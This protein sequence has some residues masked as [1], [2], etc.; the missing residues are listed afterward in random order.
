M[1]IDFNPF[2]KAYEEIVITV[3][4]AFS[5]V[6]K[7]YGDCVKCKVGCADCCYALF[8]LTLIEAIFVNHHFN[9]I[10]SGKEREHLLEIANRYDRK[11]VKIK[12]QAQKDRESGKDET[13]ILTELALQ[14]LKCPLLDDQDRCQ[15]YEFR[16]ITC[17]LYGVP[18]SIA[19]MG[20]TCGLSGFQEGTP[21]PTVNMDAIHR[22]LYTV[23]AELVEAIQSKY[24]RLAEM[25]V[26][27]SMA[28]LTDYDDTFMGIRADDDSKNRRKGD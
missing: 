4:S 6:Q 3:D 10:Y 8:D 25:L 23:S 2:F 19:G 20:H 12:R 26:P 5:T 14:R 17:R 9:R 15:L 22:R 13:E 24:S 11:V 27:L 1:P 7:K 18:T 16:P 28:L 21:Y